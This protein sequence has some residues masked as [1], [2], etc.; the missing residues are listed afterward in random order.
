MGDLAKNISRNELACRCGCGFD[1]MDVETIEAVQDACRYFADR[2][3]VDRVTLRINSAA[4]CLEYNRKPAAEGGPG[5]NDTSQHTKARAM[6]IRI[7]GV[8]PAELYHYFDTK[9][10]GK[11]GV[12]LY[13]SFVHI[14]T[15]GARARWGI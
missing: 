3:H 8:S 7:E 15:R 13:A 5:S 6:D 4:R 9:Y 1:S 12:G 10:P 2:L 14:D 11:Y